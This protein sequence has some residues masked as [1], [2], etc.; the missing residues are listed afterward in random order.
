MV[1]WIFVL[2]LLPIP[3]VAQ[4]KFLLRDGQRV[5]FLGDSNTFAGTSIAYID[6]YLFTRFPDK[7]FELIN[8]GLPSETVSGLSEPD[9]PYPRPDVHE[10][11]DRA[12]ARTK[13]N[14]VVA[15]YGMNDGIYHPFSEE[16]FAKYCAGIGKL[17]DKVA[18][19]GARIVLVTPAP[20]DPVP[21]RGKVLPPGEPK[22]S[23]MKPY[24]K[25]DDTLARY[26]RWL[27]SLKDKGFVVADPH[28]AIRQFLDDARQHE[29]GYFVSGDGIHPNATG[30][31]LIAT[32]ILEAFNAPDDVDMAEIDVKM[33]RAINGTVKDVVVTEKEIRLAWTSKLPWP[34]A[35]RSHTKLGGNKYQQALNRHDLIVSR[36]P[37]ARYEFF[38]GDKKVG[39]ASRDAL[40]LGLDLTRFPELSTNQR[41]AALGKLAQ[42]RQ[43]VLG[44]AWLTDVGH[45]RPGTPKGMAL[46]VAQKQA[47]ALE[48]QIRELAA[49]HVLHLRL[50]GNDP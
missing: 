6:A 17:I 36:L 8:L 13:P 33:Q 27:V 16:R 21:L 30:H 43:K 23:W 1:R 32:Q 14:V 15:C 5:V 19:A 4:E 20:F 37:G 35:S 40:K 46:A 39:Q 44:L 2:L 3:A 12:L 29:P 48:R 49:P 38:E 24:E 50:V 7:R 9:H 18:Q 22:Y 31:A 11:L 10:R 42:E 41:A 45:N 47:A 26:A 28:T 34:V 25:Y